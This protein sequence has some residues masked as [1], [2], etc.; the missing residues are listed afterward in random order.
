MEIEVSF[1][2]SKYSLTETISKIEQTT[3]N[4]IHV[5]VMD[6]VFV[7]NKTMEVND[8]INS[9]K[10]TTKKLDVHLM[11][12]DVISY[13]NSIANLKPFNI[14]IHLELA[15]I[16][17]L[18]DIINLIKS[19]NIQVGLAINPETDVQ[20]ILPYLTNID[21]VLIMS[22]H[23]GQGGQEFIREVL[24][25]IEYLNTL[26]NQYNFKINIDGG[27]NATTIEYLKDLYLDYIVSGS[28]IC[29]SDDYQKQIDILQNKTK[30]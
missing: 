6:G 22:V 2:A 26:K 5:D 4:I 29:C 25:K 11:V 24:A 27:I 17:N 20:E 7:P 10:N 3:A 30:E 15:K 1:L 21:Q 8:L 18:N 13:I 23:P 9:L 19:K 16:I 28:F 14:T 12:K